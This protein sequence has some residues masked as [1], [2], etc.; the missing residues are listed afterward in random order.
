MRLA[1]EVIG[2][3]D[4]YAAEPR[5]WSDDDMA[6]AGVLADMATGLLVNA[7]KLQQHQQLNDQLH[8]ALESRIVVEQAKGIIANA[9]GIWPDTAFQ[10]IRRHARSHNTSLRTVAEAIVTVGLRV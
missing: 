3:L 7:S 2:A 1:D 8:R 9:R 5:D 4:L 10:V 6:A